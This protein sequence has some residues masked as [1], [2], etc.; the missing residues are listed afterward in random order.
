[1]Q[2]KMPW[3]VADIRLAEERPPIS[4]RPPVGDH[5]PALI[6]IGIG[7]ARLVENAKAREAFRRTGG[8]ASPL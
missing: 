4:K 7:N 2:L 3:V 6:F 5:Y 8:M 1:M